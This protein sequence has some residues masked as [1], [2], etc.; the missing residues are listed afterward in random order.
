MRA[1]TCRKLLCGGPTN[2]Y[3]LCTVLSKQTRRLGRLIPEMQI[4]ELI[5]VAL[6]NCTGHEIKIEMDG[7]VPDVIRRDAMRM[8][9]PTKLSEA[10]LAFSSGPS[11]R[12]QTENGILNIE[13]QERGEDRTTDRESQLYEREADTPASMGSSVDS[14]DTHC[15]PPSFQRNQS[16]SKA[17]GTDRTRQLQ[18]RALA[19][20]LHLLATHHRDNGNYIVAHAL[21]GHALETAQA[22][23]TPEYKVDGKVLTAKIQKDRQ[24]VL[25]MLLSGE[26]GSERSP[27]ENA[28]KVV[29]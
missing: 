7:N 17:I 29:E 10:C 16:M 21:Y 18:L 2:R 12:S 24:A 6:R 14:L 13:Q 3:L 23:D 19:E 27:L 9:P 1:Q 8:F 4:S 11:D 25:E 15:D 28:Q 22:V 20:N 26:S 5:G